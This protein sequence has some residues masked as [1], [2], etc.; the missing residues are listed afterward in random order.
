[1]P[2]IIILVNVRLN[3]V[4]WHTVILV[5]YLI[6]LAMCNTQTNIT[7]FLQPTVVLLQETM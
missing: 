4:V 6:E 2:D 3:T 7:L 1:M 5:K